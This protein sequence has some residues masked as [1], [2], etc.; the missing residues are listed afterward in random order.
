MAEENDIVQQLAN[1]AKLA[2]AAA[3]AMGNPNPQPDAPAWA[4]E[5][6]FKGIDYS[7]SAETASELGWDLVAQDQVDQ[8]LA[9][10][11]V[12]PVFGTTRKYLTPAALGNEFNNIELEN[13]SKDAMARILAKISTTVEAFAGQWEEKGWY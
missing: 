11:I 13:F 8:D 2:N 10:V 12:R 6:T 4:E 3:E 9:F 1:A 5:M 7:V